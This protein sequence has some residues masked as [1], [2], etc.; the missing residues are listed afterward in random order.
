MGDALND[1]LASLPI[2]KDTKQFMADL[3]IL[4]GLYHWR[5]VQEYWSKAIGTAVAKFAGL[6]FDFH[7]YIQR[8]S[9]KN[10]KVC[11]LPYIN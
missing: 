3:Q 11:I 5:V 2:D 7:I 4:K 9:D 10:F 1:A 8:L 6:T